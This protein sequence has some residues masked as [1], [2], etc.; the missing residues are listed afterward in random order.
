MRITLL[1]H[2]L[3]IMK[4]REKAINMGKKLWK[5]PKL[6]H[7]GF[8]IVVLEYVQTHVRDSIFNK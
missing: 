7:L 8:L 3:V 2:E 5:K 1:V 4:R 6:E